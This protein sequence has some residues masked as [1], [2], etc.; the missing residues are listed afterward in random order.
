[1]RPAATRR[2]TSQARYTARDR[3][4]SVPIGSDQFRS[5]A[6]LQTAEARGGD[7]VSKRG[8]DGDSESLVERF[9]VPEAAWHRGVRH[10]LVSGRLFSVA[11]DPC[12][13]RADQGRLL[14]AGGRFH[15]ESGS[16]LRVRPVTQSVSSRFKNRQFGRFQ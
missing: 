11:V 14:P 9:A 1:M 6:V 13:G 10:Q 8:R 16:W 5:D 2:F 4:R 7:C 12:A 3:F 15:A